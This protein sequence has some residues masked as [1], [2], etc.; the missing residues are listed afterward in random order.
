M[1][2][3]L[4]IPISVLSVIFFC[5]AFFYSSVGLGGGSSYTALLA[6]IGASEATIPMV[7][8]T[9]NII[10]TTIGSIGFFLHGH[11]RLRLIA[12]FIFTSIPMA[13]LG[14]M[15]Q[16][17]KLL[18][19]FILTATLCFVAVRI[20]FPH[21]SEQIQLNQKGKSL[22]VLGCGAAL[23]LVAGITGLGGGI[24]IVP[25]IIL[26]DLG[27]TKEAAACSA[28]FICVNSVSGL[29]ARLQYNSIDLL[30]YVPLLVAVGIG[31]LAG[32]MVGARRFQARTM[33]K[34]FGIILIVAIVLLIRKMIFLVF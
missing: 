14:G 34:I 12:P 9:L 23:G 20:Y 8:L 22:V 4:L 17:P 33:H 27:T 10:V 31:G 5:I 19:Y 30:P 3:D 16:L 24:Y 2:Q 21:T 18:F 1:M 11:T 32:T 6:I 26:L 25:L 29:I 13:Y 28:L 15:L 7:S